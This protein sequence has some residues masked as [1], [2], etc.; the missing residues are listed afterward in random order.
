MSQ[1]VAV[2]QPTTALTIS[3]NQT[4]FSPGQVATLRQLGVDNASREDLA[5]FFHVAR[6]TGLDPFARQ[7]YMVGRWTKQGTKFTIQTGIDGYRLIARRAVDR[8]HETL[9]YEDTLWCGEDGNWVDV[10]LKK[11]PPAAA[12]VTVLRGG[13]RYSAVALFSEYAQTTREGGLT[14]MWRDK[15]ALMIA[16]C[17]EA[18]ALRKAFPQDLSGIYTAEE[19]AQADNEPRVMENAV[20]RIN[21]AAAQP[22]DPGYGDNASEV[23]WALEVE[24]ANNDIDAL[25]AIWKRAASMKAEQWVFNMITEAFN[26]IQEAAS[27]QEPEIVEEAA[28]A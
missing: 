18:L 20:R 10:W 25:R 16:K 1:E 27:A 5:V 15:G 13:E 24:Q 11:E 19:M 26:G 14:Q 9:G 6:R 12:K 28:E 7:I 21:E 4:E 8:T 17:A 3:E 22:V 2:K 23:D